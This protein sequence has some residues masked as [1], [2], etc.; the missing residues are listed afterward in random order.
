MQLLMV[1]I[2][3][4][5]TMLS[6]SWCYLNSGKWD[7]T[8]RRTR[9][10]SMG[11]TEWHTDNN[12]LSTVTSK[13]FGLNKQNTETGFSKSCFFFISLYCGSI[14]RSLSQKQTWQKTEQNKQRENTCTCTRAWTMERW[15]QL[16]SWSSKEHHWEWGSHSKTLMPW[17]RW[18]PHHGKG[19]SK[20]RDDED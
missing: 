17:K 11:Y 14:L 19:G 10:S 4:I 7:C 3:K 8:S 5:L 20:E 16:N 13:L 1:N 18:G 2:P 15:G 12:Y 6:R 9:K